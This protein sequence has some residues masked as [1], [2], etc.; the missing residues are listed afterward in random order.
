M[1]ARALADH[2]PS[3]ERGR[4]VVGVTLELGGERHHVGVELEDVV[5]RQQ[6][7]HDRGGA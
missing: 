7:C 2:K 4:D 5:G 3:L 1:H 6:P